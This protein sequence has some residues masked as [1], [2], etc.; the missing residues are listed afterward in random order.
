MTDCV[1]RIV[2]CINSGAFSSSFQRTLSF[3]NAQDS[4]A[5]AVK[6]VVYVLVAAMARSLWACRGMMKSA[7]CANGDCSLLVIAMVGQFCFLPSV[8]TETISGD[9]P[10]CE[11]PMIKAFLRSGGVL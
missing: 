3:A 11:I 5:K 1:P 4:I 7:C 8:K 2:S 6:D 10:D 9:W